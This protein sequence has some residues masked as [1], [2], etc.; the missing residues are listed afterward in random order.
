MRY[1]FRHT[2][3]YGSYADQ[4]N[5]FIAFQYYVFIEIRVVVYYYILLNHHQR[6]IN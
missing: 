1:R 3:V 5:V 2:S 6:Y 4:K